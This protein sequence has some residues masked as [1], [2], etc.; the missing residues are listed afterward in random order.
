MKKQKQEKQIKKNVEADQLEKIVGGGSN[1]K[2]DMPP[3][4]DVPHAPRFI[5]PPKI[6]SS[7]R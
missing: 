6:S 3:H 1:D 4:P 5:D 7:N 2:P